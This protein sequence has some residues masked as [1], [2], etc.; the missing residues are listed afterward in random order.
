[1]FILCK[2]RSKRVASMA[3]GATRTLSPRQPVVAKTAGQR[4]I[5]KHLEPLGP[6]RVPRQ[7]IAGVDAV[8]LRAP[9]TLHVRGEV[10]QNIAPP[11]QH[12]PQGA[13]VVAVTCGAVAHLLQPISSHLLRSCGI[14]EEDE[15]RVPLAEVV[16]DIWFLVFLG[17][18]P[19]VQTEAVRLASHAGQSCEYVRYARKA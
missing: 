4:S 11:P 6:V 16:R 3:S 14:A 17:D 1:M 15:A 13:L 9:P 19:P 5:R 10:V 12:A 8:A 2:I 18:A 7:I